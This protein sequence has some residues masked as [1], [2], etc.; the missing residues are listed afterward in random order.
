MAHSINPYL[1]PKSPNPMNFIIVSGFEDFRPIYKGH[2][3]NLGYR[4]IQIYDSPP[5]SFKDHVD[6]AFVEVGYSSATLDFIKNTKATHPSIKILGITRRFSREIAPVIFN[7]GADAFMA[8]VA[9]SSEIV[10]T[11]NYLTGKTPELNTKT[12]LKITGRTIDWHGCNC[13]SRDQ[14]L[15]FLKENP[16]AKHYE[17]REELFPPGAEDKPQNFVLRL[18]ERQLDLQNAENNHI[19]LRNR[20]HPK[21][22]LAGFRK[23]FSS[24]FNFR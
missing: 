9:N 22:M 15:K 21:K 4:N 24:L 18:Y 17:P 20:Q 1:P 16:T 12:P 19:K 5:E 13:V 3:E 11:I 6:I 7:A 23:L 8:V 10:S 2:L 14:Y